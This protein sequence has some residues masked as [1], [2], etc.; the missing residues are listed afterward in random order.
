MLR[1]KKQNPNYKLQVSLTSES[2]SG[3]R[4]EFLC[5]SPQRP[6]ELPPCHTPSTSHM[7]RK[8]QLSSVSAAI[9]STH[10]YRAIVAF[11]NRL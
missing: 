9:N 2:C 7:H 1:E 5:L 3:T 4:E 11:R 6:L 10:L 8:L